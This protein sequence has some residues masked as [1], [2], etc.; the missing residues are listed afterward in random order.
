MV[1]LHHSTTTC[2]L[3]LE[4]WPLFSLLIQGHLQR[5]IVR[6]PQGHHAGSLRVKG[7][8][9]RLPEDWDQ[10]S[11]HSWVSWSRARWQMLG[12]V[13]T[14]ETPESSRHVWSVTKGTRSEGLL[15]NV[16]LDSSFSWWNLEKRRLPY[17]LSLPPP[18]RWDGYMETSSLG[19]PQNEKVPHC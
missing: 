11:G 17:F 18:G 8:V 9:R 1:R 13:I 5:G 3:W 6:S 14:A 7:A 12:P 4:Y 15:L 10:T 16:V 2:P 19:D